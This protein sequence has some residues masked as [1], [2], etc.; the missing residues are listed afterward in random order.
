MNTQLKYQQLS[1]WG[2]VIVNIIL[3]LMML[4][5]TIGSP[6]E[7]A[8]KK[9]VRVGLVFDPGGQFDKSLNELSYSGLLRAEE[10]LHVVISTYSSSDISDIENQI[11]SCAAEGNDLCLSVGFLS[12]TAARIVAAEYP[13]VAFAIID[14]GSEEGPLNLRSILFDERQSGYLAGVVA[15]QMTATNKLGVVAGLEFVPAVVDFAEGFRNA[16]QCVN[17]AVEVWIE[18]TGSFSDPALGAYWAEQMVAWGAD[19]VFAPAGATGF[20]AILRAAELGAWVVGVDNDTYFWV[21]G[22]PAAGRILTSAMKNWD[23]A[24]Y[25]TIQDF[26]KKRF[27]PG[28]NEYSLENDGVGLAPFHETADYIPAEVAS[29]VEKV[30]KDIIAGKIDVYNTCR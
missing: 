10:K 25:D 19:V 20:G 8:A 23:V 5:L 15:G 3:L 4:T 6:A 7:V 14:G 17:P 9:I 26:V 12:E 2:K 11:R 24:V 29:L 27:T 30:K 1:Q 21:L 28:V 13:Q 18:Y 22:Q 16:A